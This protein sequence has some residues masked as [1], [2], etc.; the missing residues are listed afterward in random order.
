MN[1]L[2]TMMDFKL[3]LIKYDHAAIRGF[4][5]ILILLYRLDEYSLSKW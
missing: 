3:K 1:K 2:H 5:Q 4:L